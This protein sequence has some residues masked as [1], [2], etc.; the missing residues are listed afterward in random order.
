MVNRLLICIAVDRT[1]WLSS[2]YWALF[3]E[4]YSSLELQEDRMLKGI[5]IV[6]RIVDCSI[7][8]HTNLGGFVGKQLSGALLNNWAERRLI[9]IEKNPHNSLPVEALSWWNFTAS[10]LH[11]SNGANKSP[12]LSRCVPLKKARLFYCGFCCGDLIRRLV[13]C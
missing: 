6:N 12:L 7:N 3:I 4:H 13:Q 9:F 8:Y 2:V 5:G 11:F 1:K 10:C